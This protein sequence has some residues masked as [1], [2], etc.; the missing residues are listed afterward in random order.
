MSLDI[1][2]KCWRKENIGNLVLSSNT[3][4]VRG[5]KDQSAIKQFNYLKM[6][7]LSIKGE[8]EISNLIK[9]DASEEEIAKYT[10]QRNDFVFNTRNSIELVGKCGVFLHE[11]TE[12]ILFNNNLLRIRFHK[13]EPKIISFW[14]NSAEGKYQLR[15]ITSATTSVAA[16]YQKSLVSLKVP[17]PP[18]AEQQEIINQLDSLLMMV[19]SIKNRLDAIPGIIKLFRQSVLASAVSGKLTQEWREK[20]IDLPTPTE[21]LNRVKNERLERWVTVELEKKKNKGITPKNDDW[22]DKYPAPIEMYL[23][24]LNRTEIESAPI[25]WVKTNLDNISTLTT[26]KTPSTTK[27]ENWNGNLPFISPTQVLKNGEVVE[28]SRFVSELGAK[29]VPIVPKKSVL[30]VCIGT[31]GKVGFLDKDSVIN[32]QLNALT[33]LPSVHEKYL[34]YWSKNLYDWIIET[35]RSTVNAAIINKSKLSEAPFALPSIDEQ[36]E[37]VA[38]VELLFDFS[39]KVE[40][41]VSIAQE[42]VNH[43]TQSIL[44]KAF[45]GELTAE[46][47]ELNQALITGEK[48]AET[49][50]AKIKTEREALSNKK[51]KKK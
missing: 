27:E 51:S 30:I 29:S 8:F 50:L 5:A 31:V 32:Q 22:K 42:R 14:F 33:P 17:I 25:A 39:E 44:A 38:K 3:G 18:L 41:K 49:L 12:P 26:G 19:D 48:S 9:V 1:L 37:I 11:P 45:R 7:S 24:P 35:S 15:N 6:D 4:L 13:I 46:W 36:V 43:L 20:R 16:I 47:R 10:L 34:Y 21:I 2:P 23:D 40:K 28:P